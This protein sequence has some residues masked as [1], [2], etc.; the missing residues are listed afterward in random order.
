VLRALEKSPDQRQP[1]ARAFREELLKLQGDV[2]VEAP[3]R[4]TSLAVLP[5]QNLSGDP[6]EEFFAD[7]MTEALIGD[8]AQVAALR[9][10]SRTSVMRFKGSR[11]PLPE[12]ARALRVDAIVEGSVL[13]AGERVRIQAQLIEAAT[14]RHLW[15]RSYERDFGDV[16][17]LQRDIAH[18]VAGEIRVQLSPRESDRLTR[19]RPVNPEAYDAYLRGRFHWNR[20]T[21]E[22]VRR[23]IEWFDRA[24]EADPSYALAWAGLADS[25]SILRDQHAIVPD[26]AGPRARA[27]ALK[28]LEIDPLLA[29]AMVSLAFHH[30]YFDR[31][32]SEA[33]RLYRRALELQPNYATG[34][35][36]YS[37]FLVMFERAE[38]AV[39]EARRARELDPLSSIIAVSLADVFYFCRR[40]QE[41]ADVLH[42]TITSDPSFVHARNDLARTLTQLGRHDE[43]IAGFLAGARL[44]E[45]EPDLSPG[46]G[47]AY[48]AAGR[49]DDAR[50]VLAR[51]EAARGER[52]FSAQGIA[53]IHAALGDLDRAFEWLE[54]AFDEHDGA[55]SW[56]RV[57]P[58][59]DAL[60]GDSRFASIQAKLGLAG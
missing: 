11:E 58:R 29:E 31:N 39:A 46:L 23:G 15:G 25:Y 49:M 7:G 56:V 16:L 3:R 22:S 32:W 41:S 14:D 35:Q 21:P 55:L 38:E 18:A 10:I 47:Y 44:R 45:I 8:L 51:L 52:Y 2:A 6:A 19:S 59:L 28:A 50:R 60:R 26:E 36:W 30:S 53:V 54:R 17:A 9:V 13:R 33:E 37:E 43:A 40:F 42:A 4:I 1:S 48:A 12:I 5:L 20:R 24:I 57:N 34:H 27:A